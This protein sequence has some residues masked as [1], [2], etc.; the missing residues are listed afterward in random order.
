MFR[1][2]TKRAGGFTLIE[3]ALATIIVGVGIV[4]TMR[5]FAAC[6][7][8][9]SASNQ[10]TTATMLA[11]NIHETV[12]GLSFADP[13]FGHQ[14]F[15]P[16]TGETLAT[17]NDIDDFDGSTF[18]PPIDAQRNTIANLS[19]YSQVVTVWPVYPNELSAN[20]TADTAKTPDIPKSTY[21]GALRVRVR[22]MYKETPASTP[23][24]VYEASWVCMDD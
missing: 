11:N 13:T 9:A 10:I 3:A 19:N 24:Q 6:N 21:T 17:Y 20:S 22:I 4:S 8:Q 7:A 2:V 5:L 1:K 15:G 14:K 16:E 23:E 18:S 12:V